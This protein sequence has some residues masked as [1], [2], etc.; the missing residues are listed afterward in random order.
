MNNFV[1]GIGDSIHLV[2]MVSFARETAGIFQEFY[3]T[4]I[5]NF[6][7]VFGSAQFWSVLSFVYF[8]A[9]EQDL[10][11]WQLLFLRELLWTWPITI[12]SLGFNIFYN[13]NLANLSN[14]S[15]DM[16]KN[17]SNILFI[18]SEEI[19]RIVLCTCLYAQLSLIDMIKIK[20]FENNYILGLMVDFQ[21]A[22]YFAMFCFEYKWALSGWTLMDRLD[23]IELNWLYFTG[24]GCIQVLLYKFLPSCIFACT[25]PCFILLAILS[26]EKESNTNFRVPIFWAIRSIVNFCLVRFQKYFVKYIKKHA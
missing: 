3:S 25:T 20:W 12:L 1:R 19:Y 21:L 24:F 18:V 26:K 11:V 7:I 6:V 8:C 22:I 10:N 15:L 14:K 13:R 16:R 4:I 2:R 23:A 5:M 9:T 17:N